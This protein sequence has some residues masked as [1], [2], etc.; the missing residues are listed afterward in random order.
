MF[1]LAKNCCVLDVWSHPYSKF[2]KNFSVKMLIV[3]LS[4]WTDCCLLEFFD[5]NLIT[6]VVEAKLNSS[7]IILT[8][9][10]VQDFCFFFS[11]SWEPSDS[12]FIFNRPSSS[13]KISQ[14]IQKLCPL[15][16]HCLRRSAEFSQKFPLNCVKVWRKT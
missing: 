8:V 12:W 16:K 15:P 7:P 9:L 5:Q 14:T 11:W 3:H 2:F 4:F 6:V 13:W 10:N 1:L